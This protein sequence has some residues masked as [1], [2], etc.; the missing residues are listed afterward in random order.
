MLGG[1]RCVVSDQIEGR[2]GSRGSDADALES[3]PQ[4]IVTRS[5]T[6]T[7]ATRIRMAAIALTGTLSAIGIVE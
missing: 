2:F 7:I 4:P 6:A 3:V 1:G 5:N